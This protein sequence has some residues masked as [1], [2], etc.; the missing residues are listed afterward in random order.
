MENGFA[1]LTFG[2]IVLMRSALIAFVRIAV[3]IGVRYLAREACVAVAGVRPLTALIIARGPGVIVDGMFDV[4]LLR[5]RSLGLF[6]EPT[7]E[8]F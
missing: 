3:V 6:I 8:T 2:V 1:G 4:D 7:T 5:R